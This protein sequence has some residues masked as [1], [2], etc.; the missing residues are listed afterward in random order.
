MTRLPRKLD[1]AIATTLA[2]EARDTKA[3]E[4]RVDAVGVLCIRG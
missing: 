2:L 3:A 4:I 1:L